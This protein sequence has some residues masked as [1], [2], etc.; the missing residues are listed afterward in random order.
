M[1]A[2]IMVGLKRKDIRHREY[3]FKIIFLYNEEAHASSYHTHTP[4]CT[5]TIHDLQC[6]PTQDVDSMK[7]EEKIYIKM[8]V[9]LEF[10]AWYTPVVL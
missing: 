6:R 3:V 5:A 4:A 10:C 7:M 9:S 8:R 1:V 2:D